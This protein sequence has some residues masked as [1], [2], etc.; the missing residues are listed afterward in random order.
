MTENVYLAG[1]QV[2]SSLDGL[3]FGFNVQGLLSTGE[4]CSLLGQFSAA[5]PP[6]VGEYPVAP[7]ANTQPNASFV[8]Y[9]AAGLVANG[10]NTLTATGGKVDL[11]VSTV[12]DVEGTFSL[13]A[14][15]FGS[16]TAPTA[17]VGGF[18]VACIFADGPHCAAYSDTPSGGTC[19]DLLAC[20]AGDTG[21]M[22]YYTSSMPN[23]DAACGRVLTANKATYCP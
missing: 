4:M 16:G 23:G 14:A 5:V 13:V 3:T 19:A 20:C 21:C 15:P 1:Y 7:L 6:P 9:C 2:G 8:S 17:I 18:N 12:G 11:T 22:A 10:G